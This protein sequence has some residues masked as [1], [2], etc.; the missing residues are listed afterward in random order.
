MTHI[1]SETSESPSAELHR[2]ESRR[3]MNETINLYWRLRK[4]LQTKTA[5]R[6][7]NEKAQ[8]V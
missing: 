3:P 6:I 2:M 7:M 5:P 8:I 1:E 4:M